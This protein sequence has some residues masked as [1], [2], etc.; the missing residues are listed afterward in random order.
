MTDTS[1]KRGLGLGLLLGAIV[2]VG[3]CRRNIMTSEADLVLTGGAVWTVDETLPRA[4]AVAV[5]D[6]RIMAVGSEA[7]IRPSIGHRTWVMD[8]TGYLVLP[9]F[10]DSHTHFL[11]G[12]FALSR[13]QLRDACSKTEFIQRIAAKVKELEAGAWILNGNWNHQLFDPPELPTREWIDTV[14]PKNP[15]CLNRIDGHMVLCNSLALEKAGINRDTPPPPG[16]E[17]VFDPVK[18]EPTGI[19]KD[20]AADIVFDI[21]PE[22]SFEE[23]VRAAEAAVRY[24]NSLGL[25][26]VHEMAYRSPLDVYQSLKDR[27][28]LTLRICVYLPV[29][30]I[31]RLENL[32]AG[33]PPDDPRLKFGGL[34]GFADGALGSSTALFFEPY[35]DDPDRIGLLHEQMLPEGIMAVRLGRA[36]EMDLQAAVHAIGDRANHIVLDIFEDIARRNGNRDRRWRIEHAQHLLPADIERFGRLGVIASVQPYHAHD[37]GGWAETKIGEKRA[38]TTCAFRSLERAGAVLTFGSDWTVAPLD[39]LKGIWAAVTRQTADGAFP[40]GWIP[41]EKL[42]LESAVRGFT[43]NAAYAEFAEDIKGSITPGKLAD[44]VII[45]R[46]LFAGSPVDI[47]EARVQATILGG[48]IVYERGR[49]PDR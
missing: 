25:T 20:A 36:D 4:E 2:L 18:G 5:R 35:S 45:D 11:D 28:G 9:G 26:S 15:V 31:N 27:G 30:D 40:E 13:I 17:I 24:A 6:D 21:L 14:T 19:L 44:L 37:D 16:G 3:S 46:D 38:Q 12:G 42:S 43:L 29:T 47:L 22:P 48:R 41:G 39:P 7:D 32:T 8:C 49:N 23:K 33:L 10:I 1:V 34:K